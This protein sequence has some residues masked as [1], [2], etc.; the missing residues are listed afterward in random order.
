MTASSLRLGHIVPVA[1]IAVVAMSL[2]ALAISNFIAQGSLSSA[3]VI[4]RENSETATKVNELSVL[5]KEIELDIVSTQESLTDISATRGLDGLDDGFAL[6]EGS[7][8]SLREKV[9]A[10][11]E[12]ATALKEPELVDRLKSLEAQY[13]MFYKAGIEMAN[14]YIADG[15]AGGNKLMDSFDAVADK[16]QGEIES[17]GDLVAQIVESGNQQTESRFADVQSNADHNLM[18]MSALGVVMLVAGIG[19]VAFIALRLLRPLVR[20]TNAMNEL[21]RENFDIELPATGRK[22]EIGDLAR[23]Y[24]NFRER[25]RAKKAADFEAEQERQEKRNE[26]LEA[27][28]NERAQEEIRTKHVID[29][30]ALGLEQLAGGDLTCTIESPFAGEYDRLRVDFNMSV[31]KLNNTLAEIKDNISAIN[32]DASEMRSA[33][34]ELS[35]R[36]EQQAASLEETS[37][38][39]EQITATVR[40]ATDRAAEASQMAGSTQEATNR[41]GK[42]VAEA[43]DAMGRIETASGEITTIINVIDEIAFQTNLLALNAGV[44]AAR[45]GEAGMGFAVV[46]QEVRELAQRSANAAQEIKGLI[47][48]SGT[49]VANGVSLVRATGEALDEIAEKVTAINEHIASIATASQEQSTGLQ[50]INIAVGQMDQMTQQNAAMVEES[51]AVTHRLSGES[52]TLSDLISQFRLAGAQNAPAVEEASAASIPAESPARNMVRSVAHAFGG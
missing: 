46:A 15:P 35:R 45:A 43:V 40:S 10:A 3:Q 11:S 13:G 49:E 39:L 22:D 1:I 42:V 2:G 34:D 17:A 44:E 20:T 19:L 25:L 24:T 21:A 48:N 30:L 4:L 41:S 18:T 6:A 5:Q 50:E 29:T 8:K 27:R 26:E 52:D 23:A 16:M 7:S 12:L 47:Q 14:A 51:T 33:S 37:A 28:E 32:G 9:A 36:T 38:A 31:G